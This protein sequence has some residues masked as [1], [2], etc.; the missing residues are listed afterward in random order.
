[1]IL[2][3]NKITAIAPIGEHLPNLQNL[4]LVGNR[5]KAQTEVANLAVCPRL[6]NLSLHGNPVTQLPGYRKATIAVVR[7][8]KALDFKKV[9][10]D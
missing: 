1:L 8:L 7:S 6:N 10:E 2:S 4:F 5:I 3:N 9:E